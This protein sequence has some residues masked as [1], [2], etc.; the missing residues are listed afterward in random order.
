MI[1]ADTI[2]S[3]K[4]I[5]V[6]PAIP[7]QQAME[8]EEVSMGPVIRAVS[9]WK[10]PPQNTGHSKQATRAKINICKRVK[11]QQFHLYHI[12]ALMS[13]VASSQKTSRI[14]FVLWQCSVSWKEQK[15][16]ECKI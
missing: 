7:Q 2:N 10:S 16:L 1:P 15:L 14:N 13:S 6:I 3:Q 9:K 4:P 12:L 11:L 8:Q 5:P